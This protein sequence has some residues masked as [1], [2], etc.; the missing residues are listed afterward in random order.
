MEPYYRDYYRSRLELVDMIPQAAKFPLLYAG[1][2]SDDQLL[3]LIPANNPTTHYKFMHHSWFKLQALQKMRSRQPFEPLKCPLQHPSY[4]VMYI[5]ATNMA[6]PVPMI[7]YMDEAL[8]KLGGPTVIP[9]L[10]AGKLDGHVEAV[11]LRIWA[12][13]LQAL[14]WGLRIRPSDENTRMLYAIY[15]HSLHG[16]TQIFSG[17][18]VEAKCICLDCKRHNVACSCTNCIEH[19]KA[20]LVASQ[21]R[22][23]LLG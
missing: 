15:N 11:Q 14:L 7:S 13:E 6:N 4:Y 20:A 12:D 8:T 1:Y 22:H 16:S 3:A 21:I 23:A 17:H 9:D 10:V 5:P 19:R 18:P 2:L